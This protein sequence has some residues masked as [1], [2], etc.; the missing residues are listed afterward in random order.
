MARLSKLPVFLPVALVLV[1]ACS[2][3]SPAPETPSPVEVTRTTAMPVEIEMTD[4]IERPVAIEVHLWQAY[5]RDQVQIKID[6]HV[7]FSGEVT[8]DDTLSLAATIPV[9][10]SEGPHRISVKVNDSVEEEAKFGTQDL[11][12]I[13]VSYSPEEEELSF[14]FLDFRP[15]YR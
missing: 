5:S 9:T 6:E 4:T 10:V 15:A 8:T 13:A 1:L 14:E 7:I 2:R 11:M 3:L 12:V